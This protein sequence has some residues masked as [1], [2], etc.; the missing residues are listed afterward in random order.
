MK[1]IRVVIKSYLRKD[2]WIDFIGT[3]PFF[4]FDNSVFLAFRLFR[5]LKLSVYIQRIHG[6]VYECLVGYMH[7]RKEL[8]M[9]IQKLVRFLILLSYIIHTFA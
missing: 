6:L 3:I 9:N 1:D 4:A 8:L 2:F 5:I 7:S